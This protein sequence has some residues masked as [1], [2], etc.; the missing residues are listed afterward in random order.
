MCPSRVQ[1]PCQARDDS[2]ITEASGKVWGSLGSY[3]GGQDSRGMLRELGAE[4]IYHVTF[5]DVDNLWSGTG[6]HRLLPLSAAACISYLL[7]RNKSPQNAPAQN[8]NLYLTQ[9]LRAGNLGV[10]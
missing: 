4:V 10:A 6:A 7:L 5:Q 2:L 8:N 9:F 1:S 3:W